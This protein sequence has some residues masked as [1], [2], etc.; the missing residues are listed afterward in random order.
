V[1][2]WQAEI[3]ADVDERDRLNDTRGA[4]DA[5]APTYLSSTEPNRILRAFRDA[6]IAVVVARAPVGSR[7]IDLGCGGGSDAVR[8]A[9]A[10]YQVTAIDWSPEMADRTRGHA[11]RH[12]VAERVDV[13]HLGIHE[14]SSLPSGRFELAFSDLGP[15]NCVPDLAA[16]AHEISRV[17]TPDG[18][19]VASVMGRWCLWDVAANLSRGRVRRAF[20]RTWRG[21]VPVPV[22]TGTAWTRYYSPREFAAVF[23]AA[24]FRVR[25]M[26]ALG[27]FVP[28]PYLD[29]FAGRH[30]MLTDLLRR[31]ER[32]AGAWPIFCRLGDHFLIELRKQA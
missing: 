24:G 3:R 31:L 6:L 10:G 29:G 22:A 11:A 23:T 2:P 20:L 21:A 15:L 28:P 32:R 1:S 30:P 5:A 17:L 9:A 7:L 12:G 16:A 26:R 13:R 18:T 27:V 25:S 4:F 19:L 8:L 14:L